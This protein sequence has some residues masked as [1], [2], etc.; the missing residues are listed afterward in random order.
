MHWI[1]FQIH[2]RSRRPIDTR[3][4]LSQTIDDLCQADPID[5][6]HRIEMRVMVPP[7]FVERNN[8]RVMQF[9]GSTYFI[10]ETI[11][12]PLIERGSRRQLL[13]CDISAK[14]LLACLVHNSRAASANLPDNL[15]VIECR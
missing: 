10:T 9:R 4:A 7:K 6:L 3:P 2:A 5:Q 1:C 8:V 11:E 12:P 14:R 15:K 13:E